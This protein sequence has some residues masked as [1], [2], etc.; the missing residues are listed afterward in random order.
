MVIRD[1]KAQAPYS[2]D[3]FALFPGVEEA[4]QRLKEAEFLLIVVTN[5]PDVARG[6]TTRESVELINGRIRDLL[7]IDDIEICFHT[8][9]DQCFCRKPL[10][11]MLL[12][13]AKR[14]DI[15]LSRSF[16]I[17]D[18]YGDVSAGLQAGCQTFLVGPGDE[19]G[20]HPN[21]HFRKSSL[22]ECADLILNIEA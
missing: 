11:G 2:L 14:W 18:R 15:D 19:Q 21:P 3:E 10:P 16:M 17:G 4:C 8:N 20:E 6:W 5:Q 12:E 9:I 1:G 22:F 13:A 7:P